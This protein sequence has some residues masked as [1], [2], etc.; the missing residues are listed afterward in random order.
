MLRN[1]AVIVLLAFNSDMPVVAA[2]IFTYG[3][4]G[5]LIRHLR[6]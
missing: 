1:T 4:C 3:L 6:W 2:I 5:R